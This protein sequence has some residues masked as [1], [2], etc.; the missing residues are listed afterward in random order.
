LTFTVVLISPVG[1]APGKKEF[2]ILQARP[3]STPLYK[4]LWVPQIKS[5]GQKKFKFLLGA[6]LLL[7][8]PRS[9]TNHQ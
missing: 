3:Q 5:L 8:R 2:S 1:G 7:P 9:L 4:D 6:S